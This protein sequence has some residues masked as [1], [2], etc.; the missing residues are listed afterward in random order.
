LSNN[1]LISEGLLTPKLMNNNSGHYPISTASPNIFLGNN[2]NNNE[3]GN[4]L[5]NTPDY[6][7]KF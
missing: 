2:G 3:K 6:C 5:C 7:K 1:N 4:N